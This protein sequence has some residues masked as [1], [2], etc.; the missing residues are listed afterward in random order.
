MILPAELQIS[1]SSALHLN[2][3]TPP[4]RKQ[5]FPGYV[6]FF[7]WCAS[8]EMWRHSCR[9]VGG[10][11]CTSPC[12][13]RRALVSLASCTR[14]CQLSTP[15]HRKVL[16]TSRNSINYK[17]FGP[18]SNPLKCFITGPQK[19]IDATSECSFYF[20]RFFKVMYLFRLCF[21]NRVDRKGFISPST[22]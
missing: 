16:C 12:D 7:D 1:S 20:L 9:C 4:F 21:I 17:Y 19:E 5:T 10:W 22:L 13:F 14:S 3:W 15:I 6:K 2:A 18:K 11:R 8:Y